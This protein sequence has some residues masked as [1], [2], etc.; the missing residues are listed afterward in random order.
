MEYLCKDHAVRED[1]GICAKNTWRSYLVAFRKPSIRHVHWMVKK[2]RV[3]L[4]W[5]I[6]IRTLSVFRCMFRCEVLYLR[7][8][9]FYLYVYFMSAFE[10]FAAIET[11]SLKPRH[12][13]TTFLCFW[14]FLARSAVSVA[15]GNTM[16]GTGQLHWEGSRS[17]CHPGF[18]YI[19]ICCQGV[20]NLCNIKEWLLVCT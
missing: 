19:H 9:W 5:K 18:V 15:D 1:G 20:H 11:I 6:L 13:S 17:S 12:Y 4:S 8:G 7:M 16:V 10:H 2:T 14:E 3:L